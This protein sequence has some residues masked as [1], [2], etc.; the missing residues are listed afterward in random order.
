M[1][2]GGIETG[3]TKKTFVVSNRGEINCA[4]QT[5]QVKHVYIN[6]FHNIIFFLNC[7]GFIIANSDLRAY[8]PLKILS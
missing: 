7:R 4:I 6:R 5:F 8:V 1:R 3:Y 2:T